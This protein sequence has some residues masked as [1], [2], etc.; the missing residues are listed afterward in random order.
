MVARVKSGQ[1]PQQTLKEAND[2]VSSIRN[3]PFWQSDSRALETLVEDLKAKGVV[4]KVFTGET[5][6]AAINAAMEAGQKAGITPNNED[7]AGNAALNAAKAAE[8]NAHRSTAG[9][10]LRKNAG[11]QAVDFSAGAIMEDR[12]W[13]GSS[14]MDSAMLSNWASL[15]NVPYYAELK[16]SLLAVNDLSFPDKAKHV[17]FA[18]ACWDI[19]KT[20]N[21]VVG[22]FNG[23]IYAFALK[24]TVNQKAS[25][26]KS[27][28][29]LQNEAIKG[30]MENLSRS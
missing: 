19:I 1:L 3:V 4:V 12:R 24:D 6:P 17:A 5:W 18:D 28:D 21:G 22:D 9:E 20:G 29:E 15:E 16:V 27:F 13:I 11:V 23:V 14:F 30:V 26:Q 2:F 8:K 10:R 25:S 7:V